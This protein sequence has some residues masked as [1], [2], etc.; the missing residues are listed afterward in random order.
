MDITP[1]L[2][3]GH[4][5]IAFTC[6]ML[7][8]IAAHSFFNCRLLD[9]SAIW[10]PRWM[11]PSRIDIRAIPPRHASSCSSFEGLRCDKFKL[12]KKDSNALIVRN[13]SG[14]GRNEQRVPK[15]TTQKC[16]LT[17]PRVTVIYLHRCNF[18]PPRSLK[19]IVMLV[20]PFSKCWPYSAYVG[21]SDS[22]PVG[23]SLLEM[24]QGQRVIPEEFQ[25][26][27]VFFGDEGDLLR[28]QCLGQLQ[29]LI[30]LSKWGIQNEKK[31]N[32][33]L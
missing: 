8:K 1:K 16:S 29:S 7:S 31:Q 20:N 30:P 5:Y 11:L 3:N 26:L 10:T 24:L 23:E 13:W 21:L 14:R 6:F 22:I 18:S 4:R 17:Q 25:L 19:Q 9:F 12:F 32:T 15:S 33:E 2:I 27:R 28:R